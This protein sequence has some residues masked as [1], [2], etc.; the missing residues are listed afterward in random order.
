MSKKSSPNI[1]S[2]NNS[3]SNSRSSNVQS[4][5]NGSSFDINIQKN[6]QQDFTDSIND[7][8]DQTKNNINKSIDESKNQIPQ[9]NNIVNSY[10]EQSLQAAREISENFIES[11]KAIINSIQSAWR[12]YQRNFNTILNNTCN[13]QAAEVGYKIFINTVAEN[14]VT[15]LRT[16][17][18]LVF[19]SLDAFKTTIQHSK[20]TTRQIFDMN[21]KTAKTLEQK[22]REISASSASA[23]SQQ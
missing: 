22:T 5:K 4:I 10:Q 21:A 11:Q 23:S 18:N 17:N 12:P 20:D 3:S 8:L 16:T 1:T 7:V 6:Q 19:S 9:Y 13:P 14:T 2:N 15:A